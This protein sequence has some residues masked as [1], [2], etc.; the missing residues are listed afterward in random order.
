MVDPM[1]HFFTAVVILPQINQEQ[2]KLEGLDAMAEY[3]SA[4]KFDPESLK[5][6]DEV[7]KTRYDFVTDTFTYFSPE[8]PS[9]TR[10][11]G[12]QMKENLKTLLRKE[13]RTIGWF[14]DTVWALD[15]NIPLNKGEVADYVSTMLRKDALTVLL[16][17]CSQL[18]S[19]TTLKNGTVS[20]YHPGKIWNPYLDREKAEAKKKN[21]EKPPPDV[22]KTPPPAAPSSGGLDAEQS[23]EVIIKHDPNNF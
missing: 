18:K 9:G 21:V 23:S 13:A 3:M 1:R 11:S 12:P 4:L 8:T 10:V 19:V 17:C 7:S 20:K 2:T 16:D 6:M 15:H 14:S 22:K 5:D